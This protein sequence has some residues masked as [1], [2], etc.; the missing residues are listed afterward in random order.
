[1]AELPKIELP[2]K[3]ERDPD[4]YY[5]KVTAEISFGLVTDYLSGENE[6]DIKEIMA[7]RYSLKKGEVKSIEAEP[8]SKEEFLKKVKQKYAMRSKREEKD[9]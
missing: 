6:Q 1:M 7:K 2:E 3:K 4:S 8:I 9:W 5:Y